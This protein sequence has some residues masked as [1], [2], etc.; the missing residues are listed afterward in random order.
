MI[1]YSALCMLYIGTY[2]MINEIGELEVYARVISNR[3]LYSYCD[4]I[5]S[6]SNRSNL[7]P[8]S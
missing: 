5:N 6:I 2:T 4:K 1:I 7:L 8:T 3:R